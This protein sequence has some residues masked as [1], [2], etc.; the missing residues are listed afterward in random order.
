MLFNRHVRWNSDP[1]VVAS[2]LT[3]MS[4]AGILCTPRSGTFMHFH[5]TAGN[6]MQCFSPAHHVFVL[7]LSCLLACFLR[8]RPHWWGGQAKSTWVNPTLWNCLALCSLR[9]WILCPASDYLSWHLW[10]PPWP[11]PPSSHRWLLSA[12]SSWSSSFHSGP[13]SRLS[14]QQL[15]CLVLWGEGASTWG[16][17]NCTHWQL[18]HQLS[19]LLG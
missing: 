17:L 3:A 4:S 19:N 9:K 13:H 8:N 18:S 15:E 14:R 5:H 12:S 6:P 7:L 1:F 10:L 16:V 2:L 11:R